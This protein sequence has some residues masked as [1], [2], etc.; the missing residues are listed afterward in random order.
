MKKQDIIKNFKLGNQTD[1]LELNINEFPSEEDTYKVTIK[2]A[3]L[4]ELATMHYS[5][6][7]IL[8]NE[9]TGEYLPHLYD[10][11]FDTMIVRYMTDIEIDK[12]NTEE[13][14]YFFGIPQ[15]ADLLNEIKT[16]KLLQYQINNLHKTVDKEIEFKLQEKLHTNEDLN[17]FLLTANSLIMT[18]NTLANSHLDTVNN[19]DLKGFVDKFNSIGDMNKDEFVDRI[20]EHNKNIK[21]KKITKK[22]K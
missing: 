11:V 17:Q 21:P 5:I 18:L 10:F 9:D 1:T 6:L 8:F 22:S 19:T 13:V 3:T 15:V 2:R 20:L 14:D 7:N 4:D 12:Y 16:H